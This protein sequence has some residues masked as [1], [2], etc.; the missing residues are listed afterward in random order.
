[1]TDCVP[2][3]SFPQLGGHPGCPSPACKIGCQLEVSS[4]CTAWTRTAHMVWAA[5]M[6]WNRVG[7]GSTDGRTAPSICSVLN[8]STLFSIPDL[9]SPTGGPRLPANCPRALCLSRHDLMHLL[10][11]SAMP[12]PPC[13]PSPRCSTLRASPC[14]W[15][16]RLPAPRHRCS[17]QS[18][19]PPS[20]LRCWRPL[21]R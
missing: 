10:S 13:R 1:M 4:S 20:S 5:Q 16:W 15:F 18:L 14:C 21:V 17:T 19:A 8:H 9:C 6:V 12:L 7:D 2:A 11:P 3:E